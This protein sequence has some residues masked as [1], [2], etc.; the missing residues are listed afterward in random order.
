MNNQLYTQST[1]GVTV[2]V[3]AFAVAIP[4]DKGARGLYAK[5]HSNRFNN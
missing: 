5:S 1:L 4:P 2:I 3:A